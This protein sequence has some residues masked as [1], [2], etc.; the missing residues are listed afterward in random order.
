MSLVREFCAEN[1]TLVPAAV[2]AGARRIELCDN[3]AVGG[4]SPSYGV[5]RAAVAFARERNVDIMAMCR[6]RGG[7]FAYDETERSMLADDVRCA[8][9]LGVTGAVFGCVCPADDGRPVIDAELTRILVEEA[10]GPGKG[11]ATGGPPLELTFHMAFDELDL[12]R[13][14][15]ALD[16]LASLG[17]E[18]VLSHGGP[19]STPIADNLERLERLIGHA[20]GRIAIMPGGGVTWQN[21]QEIADAL[22][23]SQVHGSRIVNLGDR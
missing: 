1:M 2:A 23:V 8:R 14:L 16:L 21:A 11:I 20:A 17:V 4:T 12:R 22:G 13:Q 7:S 18:R 9:T 15:E 10:K 6:P 3:L 19:L 5:L